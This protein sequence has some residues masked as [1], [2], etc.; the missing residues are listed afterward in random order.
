M[1]SKT[2]TASN[3]TMEVEYTVPFDDTASPLLP[4]FSDGIFDAFYSLNSPDA[5]GAT[6]SGRQFPLEEFL[7]RGQNPALHNSLVLQDK[8]PFSPERL[9][10][11]DTTVLEPIMNRLSLPQAQMPAIDMLF[12]STDRSIN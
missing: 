1:S 11:V 5:L 7:L 10:A 2:T 3:I 12:E 6:N 8:D 4:S 9:I